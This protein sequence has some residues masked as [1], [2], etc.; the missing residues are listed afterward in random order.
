MTEYRTKK[1][2]PP[3]NSQLIFSKGI[4]AIQW[5]WNTLPKNALNWTTMIFFSFLKKILFIC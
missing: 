2:T 5:S 3:Q 1:K 4:K